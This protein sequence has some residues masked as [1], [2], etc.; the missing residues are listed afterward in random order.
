[1]YGRAKA[2]AFHSNDFLSLQWTPTVTFDQ[3]NTK[4]TGRKFRGLALASNQPPPGIYKVDLFHVKEN[5]S[6]Y[7]L[8]FARGVLDPVTLVFTAGT[9]SSPVLI[10]LQSRHAAAAYVNVRELAPLEVWALERDHTY[11][12]LTWTGD[13]SIGA[14]TPLSLMSSLL[15]MSLPNR[16]A[17]SSPVQGLPTTTEMRLMTWNPPEIL[18]AQKGFPDLTGLSIDEGTRVQCV[19]LGAPN[20]KVMDEI[21]LTAAMTVP[22]IGFS[23]E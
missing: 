4:A 13:A 3:L 8:L 6:L 21:I 10:I 5:P 20:T 23:R 22:P 17:L 7:K 1:M 12:L 2:A 15:D 9:A 19:L 11:A 18:R 14:E 16:E